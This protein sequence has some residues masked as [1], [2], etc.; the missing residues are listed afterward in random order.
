[1]IKLELQDLISTKSVA[2]K[3]NS[4]GLGGITFVY[5][6]KGKRIELSNRVIQMLKD[7]THIKFCF[8]DKHLILISVDEDEDGANIIKCM[9]KRKV[10]YNVNL[11]KEILEHFK[12]DYKSKSSVTLND[13][14]AVEGINNAIAVKIK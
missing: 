4:Y 1:M 7:P 2:N 9:N 13:I 5:H 10:I 8:T 3:G 11:I 12:I 14:E 6:N